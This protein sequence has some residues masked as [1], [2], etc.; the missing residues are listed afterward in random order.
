MQEPHRRGSRPTVVHRIVAGLCV[1]KKVA[2]GLEA[3]RVPVAQLRQR[4]LVALDRIGLDGRDSAYT[5][6]PP[7]GLRQRF[8]PA[9]AIVVNSRLVLME[10]RLAQQKAQF[11]F[12]PRDGTRAAALVAKNSTM[13]W[14]IAIV[15]S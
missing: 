1:P 5:R 8:G 2:L 15:A 3:Q 12:E 9:R 14:A 7:G 4:A 6:G 13:S 11:R 10:G